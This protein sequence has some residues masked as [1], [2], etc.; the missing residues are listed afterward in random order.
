MPPA[1][2]DATTL[3]SEY[4]SRRYGLGRA[5]H[6][7]LDRYILE[8][9]SLCHSDFFL[10]SNDILGLTLLHGALSVKVTGTSAADSIVSSGSKVTIA[11]G[12]GNDT[13]TISK[14]ADV[15]LVSPTD[16]K[17]L[18]TNFGVKDTLRAT[19]GT[20]KAGVS[21]SSYMVTISG[22]ES[23]AVVTLK[24]AASNVLSVKGA[25]AVLTSGKRKVNS[26]SKTKLT[27]SN[28]ADSISASGKNVTIVGGKRNDT[29][30]GSKNA[31]VILY[32]EG[33]GKDIITNFG[34]NDSLRITSGSIKN[35]Y[36]SGKDYVINVSGTKSSGSI[37]LKNVSNNYSIFRLTIMRSNFRRNPS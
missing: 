37:T 34:A 28:Y 11:P 14:N 25:N 30:S 6:R 33:D 15:I 31:D 20:L 21:G 26:K 23:S 24:G 9:P 16:G 13:L 22:D 7:I 36:S 5:L 1:Q 17:D 27:G 32:A 4:L 12:A 29:I 35:Y 10:H 2:V 3:H 18:V 19:S 8:L